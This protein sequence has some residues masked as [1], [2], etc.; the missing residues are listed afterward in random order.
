MG[1]WKAAYQCRRRASLATNI[2]LACYGSTCKS[3]F[4]DVVSDDSEARQ[5]DKRRILGV[6][7]WPLRSRAL[8]LSNTMPF[9]TAATFE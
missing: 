8:E 3:I 1:L 9:E 2:P 7:S 5:V 6:T 4:Y